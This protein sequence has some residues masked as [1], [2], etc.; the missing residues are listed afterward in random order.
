MSGKEKPK[1]LGAIEVKNETSG[2]AD[3]YIHGTILDDSW[4]GFFWDDND[5][6]GYILPA[7]VRNALAQLNG[8]NLN[9]YINSD[10]GTVT[11][12]VAIANMLQRHNG[13]VKAVVDGWAA[14]IAS[15]I[16][17]ACDELVMPSNTWLM[18][19]K[20]SVYISGNAD[21]LE[22][23]IQ[24]LDTIQEGIEKTYQSKALAG[25]TD[26][27]IHNLVNNETWMTADE[28]AKLFNITVIEPQ[29]QVAACLG[30]AYKTFMHMPEQIKPRKN[31]ENYVP[32]T[33]AE[34]DNKAKTKAFIMKSL[35]L[36]V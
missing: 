35:A 16:F 11:A 19:H 8:K 36:S 34:S 29:M 18:V 27:V 4:N 9:V 7:D 26:E 12:G 1:M 15:V 30:S 17:M 22:K 20:P 14:S 31:T 3:V 23:T 25:T 13:H 5:K 24:F 2:A 6:A 32:R 21:E 10:G 33:N 28:A